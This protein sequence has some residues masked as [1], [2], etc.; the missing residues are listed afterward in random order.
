MTV[1]TLTGVGFTVEGIVGRAVSLVVGG[2]SGAGV[3]DPELSVTISP[4]DTVVCCVGMVL[5]VKSVCR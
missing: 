1:G 3:C 4:V 5:P 2:I